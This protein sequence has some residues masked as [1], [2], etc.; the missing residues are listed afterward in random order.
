MK[1][2]CSCL[3]YGVGRIKERETCVREMMGS[4]QEEDKVRML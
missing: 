2:E 3:L 1:E 4:Q